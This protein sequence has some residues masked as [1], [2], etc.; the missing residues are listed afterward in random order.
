MALA[1]RLTPMIPKDRSYI[2]VDLR[3]ATQSARNSTRR[4][5]LGAVMATEVQL[6]Q[7]THIYGK[8]VWHESLK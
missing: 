2:C 3:P 5:G 4:L 1:G 6:N 8:P 7:A